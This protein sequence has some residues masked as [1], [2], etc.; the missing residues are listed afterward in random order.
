MATWKCAGREERSRQWYGVH[1][2]SGRKYLSRFEDPPGKSLLAEL[3]RKVAQN[4]GG[5]AVGGQ[6]KDHQ[7][8][9]F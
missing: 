5:V 9:F 1:G 6:G 8:A 2:G 4:E 3:G 7:M